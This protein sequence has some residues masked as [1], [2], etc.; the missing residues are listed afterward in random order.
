MKTTVT[1][2]VEID[3]DW[4]GFFTRYNDLFSRNYC[5]YWLRLI[6]SDAKRG[7]LAWEDDEQHDFD[8]EP[9]RREALAA[10]RAGKPL[11]KGWHALTAETAVKA[12]TEGVK[13]WGV[14]WYEHGDATRYDVVTQM[15]LLGEI[16]YG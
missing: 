13:R 3:Q 16:R 4:I 2:D 5:G 12:W 8:K 7:M 15:A 1:F 11:P 9:D 10:W 6:K 14:D